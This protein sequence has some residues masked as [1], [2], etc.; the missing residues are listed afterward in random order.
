MQ[1]NRKWWLRVTGASML[2]FA[3]TLLI[4]AVRAE[5]LAVMR[6]LFALDPTEVATYL[7]SFGWWAV[8]VSALLM[9]GQ[10]LFAPIPSFLLT[11]ANALVF[12]WGWGALISWSSAMLGAALC[13][14]LARLLGRGW[15]ER[16]S[17]LESVAA[18][19]R[20]FAKYGVYAIVLARLLPV[21]PF[22]L[23]SYAAGLTAMR[24][25]AFWL[26]TGV[27]QLPATIIYSYVGGRLTGGAKLLFSSLLILFGIGC[28]WLFLK[29]WWSARG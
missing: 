1:R 15:V 6:L 2:V 8:F 19:D 16:L 29:K 20:F 27:G 11:I 5:W 28:V 18:T 9:I 3:V 24:F 7:R 21:M 25:R 14:G 12:G 22:D 4:P 17:G 10:S 23:V 26:A 13:F